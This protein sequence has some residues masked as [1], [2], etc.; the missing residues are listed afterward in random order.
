MESA[1]ASGNRRTVAGERRTGVKSTGRCYVASALKVRRGHALLVGLCGLAAAGA[2]GCGGGERQDENE[3]DATYDVEV[4]SAK[5]P[6]RQRLGQESELAITVRNDDTETVP[7]VAMTVHG[8][9]YRLDEPDAADTGRPDIADPSRPVFV[10]GG[11]E[12]QLGG[13]PEVKLDAPEGGSTALVNTWTLGALKPGAQTTFRWRVTAVKAGP[14]EIAYEVA[15]G[16][17]GKAKAV[18]AAGDPPRGKFSGTITAK[19]PA[20]RIAADGVTV[21]SP[22]P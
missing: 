16:L 21:V 15:G 6:E 7:D 3:A 12:K 18:T 17:D 11:V 4:V 9:Y 19:A 14:F 13:Y 22:A 20:S 8:F 10:I 5:F 2:I 1:A